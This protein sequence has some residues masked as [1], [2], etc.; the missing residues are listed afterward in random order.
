VQRLL[1]TRYLDLENGAAAESE[2]LL[3]ILND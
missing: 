2:A 3:P 1:D